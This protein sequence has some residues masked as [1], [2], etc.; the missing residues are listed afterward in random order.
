MTGTLWTS[1]DAAAATGGRA[2]ASWAARSVSIDTRSLEPGAL[3]VALKDVRDG[4][5]FVADALAKGAAAALVSRIPEGV[6]ADAPLLVVPDVLAALRALAAAARAR[7]RATVVG[8]TGSVGKTS[9]KEMLRALLGGQGVVHA[10]EKS[11]N[12]HWGVPL[13]LARMPAD[14]D[15]AVI[16]I[17]MN[18]PGE[19]APLARLADLDAALITIVAPA[20]LA[21]FDSIEGI[22]REK[23]AIFEG[24]RPGGA[25]VINAD[26]ETAPILVDA[27]RAAGAEIVTFGETGAQARLVETR[28]EA[29]QTIVK[30]RITGRDGVSHPV[31]FKLDTPGRHFAMNGLGA[32]A[33]TT[34]IGCDLA[35]AAHD[36]SRWKPYAGRGAREVVSLDIVDETARIELI[37]DSYNANPAS[38]GAALDMLAASAPAGRRIAILGDMLE[39]GPSEAALHAA[40]ADH[41]A[42][43]DIAQVHCVGP[44][45]RALWEALPAAKQGCWCAESGEMAG[46]VHTLLAPG[47]IVLVKGSLGIRLAR[48]VDAIRKLGQPVSTT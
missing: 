23:A 10:A 30:A 3:F 34:A 43:Q 20:H 2:T 15:F 6:A 11:Y 32:L 27:A 5:D 13:T 29:G 37:D 41:P 21:A 24:V 48:V 17:G 26:I 39:L 19:I 44:R 14:A 47:D 12:N 1:D 16:E 33:L 31:V 22:A 40:L 36:F 7:T 42:M 4:H 38:V 8:V 35:I 28:H 25:A 9:T 46:Q 45:A 18:H